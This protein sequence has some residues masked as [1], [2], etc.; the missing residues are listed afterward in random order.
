MKHMQVNGAPV[1]H[2]PVP[3]NHK[4]FVDSECNELRP[5]DIIIASTYSGKI[6]SGVITRFTPKRVYYMKMYLT[7]W[8]VK[9]GRTEDTSEESIQIPYS[10]YLCH[11]PDAL[12]MM[13]KILKVEE[14]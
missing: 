11:G 10:G 14:I 5:G 8:H 2:V 13:P 3:R 12:R 7:P 4:G 9:S 6:I 1:K